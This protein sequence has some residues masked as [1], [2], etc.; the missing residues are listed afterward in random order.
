MSST[1]WKIYN[2]LIEYESVYFC[3]KT[4]GSKSRRHRKKIKT[5]KDSSESKAK[6]ASALRHAPAYFSCVIDDAAALLCDICL[7]LSA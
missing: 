4:T 7:N 1:N 6:P 5:I 3:L 2:D